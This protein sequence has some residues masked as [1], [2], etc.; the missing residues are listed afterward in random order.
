MVLKW[1]PALPMRVGIDRWVS[2]PS[3]EPSPAPAVT[4][5]GLGLDAAGDAAA[6]A[7]AVEAQAALHLR[8]LPLSSCGAVTQV[9]DL[10]RP[11]AKGR[12]GQSR[13]AAGRVRPYRERR[14]AEAVTHRD[15][16]V[17]A[18]TDSDTE[19]PGMI[20]PPAI[21]DTADRLQP[22]EMITGA[23]DG[24]EGERAAASLGHVYL[25]HAAGPS[26]FGGNGG[27]AGCH[28]R[29]LAGEGIDGGNVR[30]GRAPADRHA[31]DRGAV[32]VARGGGEQL[33]GVPR[34]DEGGG[35]YDP[36]RRRPHLQGQARRF[37]A[38]HGRDGNRPRKSR[39]DGS[40]RRYPRDRLIAACPGDRA[41]PSLKQHLEGMRYLHGLGRGD[42]ERLH[43]GRGRRSHGRRRVSACQAEDRQRGNE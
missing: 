9:P 12:S 11:P 41:A 19:C 40:R 7:D 20:V 8:G 4:V 26:A 22:T 35:A 13:D 25:Y 21:G 38:S 29:H 15:R 37:S 30:V 1:K 36:D 27:D 18:V 5:P 43:G 24:A 17:F 42:R 14:K 32:R 6:R 3:D 10:I 23:A 39:G 33:P 34:Q 31:G 2:V 16:E 28:S